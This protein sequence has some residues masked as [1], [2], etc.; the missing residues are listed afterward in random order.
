[1]CK[2]D[3]NYKNASTFYFTSKK[4]TVSSKCV[5]AEL[6]NWLWNYTRCSYLTKLVSSFQDLYKFVMEVNQDLM[7]A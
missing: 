7:F 2:E 6:S 4:I 3:Q 5:R 1:M